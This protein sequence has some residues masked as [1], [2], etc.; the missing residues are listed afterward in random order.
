MVDSV[1]TNFTKYDNLSGFKAKNRMLED[2]EK[3]HD[4]DN[5]QTS[6]LTFR[7]TVDV[8]IVGI[9]CIFGL[10]GNIISMVVMRSDKITSAKTTRFLLQGLSVSDSSFLIMAFISAT[11]RGIMKYTNWGD[12]FHGRY[13]HMYRY[14]WALSAIARLLAV[15]F[16]VLVT[17]ERYIATCHPLNVKV[18][19]TLKR[20]RITA[21]ITVLA[22][23]LLNIPRFFDLNPV[24]YNYNCTDIV[25]VGG[26]ADYLEL[27][28]MFYSVIYVTVVY[29]TADVI[30]PLT[31]LLILNA[32]IITTLKRNFNAVTRL[33]SSISQRAAEKAQAKEKSITMMCFVVVVV[34]IICQTP[35]FACNIVYTLY[36]FG[37]NM[38]DRN[39]MTYWYSIGTALIVLNSATNIGIYF[40][41]S[42]QFRR[43]LRHEYLSCIK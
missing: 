33:G 28:G 42:K 38:P 14:I 12:P 30:I 16:V 19:C 5:Y 21:T 4:E 22:S 36:A 1:S 10:L 34:F 8:I 27:N 39:I 7:I 37:V 43:V 13:H 25:H 3:C 31:I 29:Y 35:A 2:L 6:Y 26:Y 23:M 18:W 11:L 9:L 41:F 40:V 32:K 17:I 24:A 15:N 20:I